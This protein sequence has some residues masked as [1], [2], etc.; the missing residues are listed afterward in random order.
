MLDSR[1]E[2]TNAVIWTNFWGNF[3]QY[4]VFF[5]FKVWAFLNC[6]WPNFAF[7]VF[8][9]SQP[10][11]Q[12]PSVLSPLPLP[13]RVIEAEETL[14]V[15]RLLAAEA[16]LLLLTFFLNLI[17]A[18]KFALELRLRLQLPPDHIN[19]CKVTSYQD[20]IT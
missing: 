16:D 6:S 4:L 9:T 15:L 19:L 7:S 14:L 20:G 2:S 18:K 5:I 12:A 8:W 13:H 1:F 3:G 11:S 17:M 10:R